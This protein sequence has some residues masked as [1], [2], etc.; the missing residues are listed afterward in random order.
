MIE[1]ENVCLTYRKKDILCGAE[2]KAL[3]GEITVILGRNGSGKTS[4]FRCIAGNRH[5]CRGDIR[6]QG[7]DM[8]SMRPAQRARV[9]SVMPQTLPL[10]P[11]TAEELV[12]F[13]RQPYL[14]YGGRLSESEKKGI[15][16]VMRR[17]GVYPHRHEVVSRLSGGERQL[18]F[19]TM[20]LAQDTP[21]VLLDEPTANLDAEYRHRVYD[22]M[23]ELRDQGRTVAATLHSLEDAVA[24]AD[25]IYVM[26]YGRT[27]FSGTPE[28]FVS[29]CVPESVFGVRAVKAMSPEGEEFTVFP[30]KSGEKA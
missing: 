15:A 3:P 8:R 22:M 25:R 13:G 21:I 30:V 28:E 18:A 20:L 29:G 27:V 6:L 5:H 2:L 17:T 14:G 7:S 11:V 19:F 10:P 1:C 26:E 12:S 4:L 9:L 24:L 23:R 16:D